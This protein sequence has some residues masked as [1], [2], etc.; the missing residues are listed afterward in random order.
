MKF[1]TPPAWPQ[2]PDG[3]LP[4]S[5]WKPDQAWPSAPSDWHFWENDYGV[6]V[7]GPPGLYA[8]TIARLRWTRR[9]LL[10]IGAL[11]VLFIGIGIGGTGP[12]ESDARA[13]AALPTHTSTVT[14]SP[15]AA[16]TVTVTAPAETVT[17]PAETVTLPAETV[18]IPADTTSGFGLVAPGGSAGSASAYYANCSEARAA[19]AAPLYRGEPGYRSGLDR[20]DDGVACES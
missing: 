18:T 9:V 4:D 10:G 12:S 11:L 20:D 1:R 14:V 6:P 7:E 2:P 5:G 13:L 16:S 15:S 19:G 3:W 8:G 17:L